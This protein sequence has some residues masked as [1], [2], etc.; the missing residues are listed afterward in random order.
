MA[1]CAESGRF[2]LA[3]VDN[4]TVGSCNLSRFGDTGSDE[5]RVKPIA[6]VKSE[7]LSEVKVSL[8]IFWR[9][10]VLARL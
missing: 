7:L 4:C 6:R 10:E 9:L 1:R 3:W 5:L 2:K 8:E